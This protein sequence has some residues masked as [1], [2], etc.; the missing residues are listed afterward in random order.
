M[1]LASYL[2]NSGSCLDSCLL[3]V[4]LSF[5]KI[6]R[7]QKF[8]LKNQIIKICIRISVV[9]IISIYISFCLNFHRCAIVPVVDCPIANIPHIVNEQFLI[10]RFY[11]NVKLLR[12]SVLPKNR[13]ERNNFS[14]LSHKIT[15]GLK[16]YALPPVTICFYKFDLYSL[17]FLNWHP[18][19]S[20]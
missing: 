1:A 10:L 20:D 5:S 11:L 7:P 19:N 14:I 18:I 6:G 13:A 15:F 4:D 2:C 17:P 12:R 3:I 8:Y 9:A 16:D